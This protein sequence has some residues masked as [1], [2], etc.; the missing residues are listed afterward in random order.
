MTVRLTATGGTSP[1]PVIQL[2][3]AD[4]TKICEAYTYG[5][6]LTTPTCVL[7]SNGDYT[8]IVSSLDT[9]TGAY[10]MILNCQIGTCGA[11]TP[12]EEHVY[13]PFVRR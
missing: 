9:G 8:V 10:T 2:F 3:S 11:L 12:P 1:H 5:T 6:T 4:G 7:P 13:L